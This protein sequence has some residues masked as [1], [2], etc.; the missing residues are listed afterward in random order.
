[1]FLGRRCMVLGLVV[2]AARVV[3]LGLMVVMRRRM[4]VARC[5]VMM[6]LRRVFCHLSLLPLLRNWVGP[7][8]A[9][10]TTPADREVDSI[11]RLALFGNGS[12]NCAAKTPVGRQPS[13]SRATPRQGPHICLWRECCA[14]I[15]LRID[16]ERCGTLGWPEASGANEMDAIAAVAAKKLGRFLAKDFREIFGSTQSDEAER[17]GALARTT[18]E[19]IS[20]SDALYHTYEHTMLVT[21][22]GRDILHGRTLAHG[23]EPGDY[24]HLIVACLLHDIGFV[25]GVLSGD[26]KTEFVVDKNGRTVTLPRGASDA[27]LAPYHV[28]RSKLFVYE[29][30]GKSASFDAARVAAAIELTRFPPNGNADSNQTTLEQRLVQAADLIGQLGDPLYPRKANAL[31][32]EF[33]EIGSNRQLGYASPADLVEKFP[34]FY[35]TTVSAHVEEGMKYLTLTAAGRQWIANLHNHIFNAE[36]FNWLMGPQI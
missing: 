36:H 15:I 29:R 9:R 27:S 20:R 14:C 26:T 10:P 18:L 16:H 32:Y 4:V 1:M 2:L 30:L 6:L 33:E 22:V 7:M 23:L 5:G 12:R 28:D 8:V 24:L 19:C 3:M 13:R 21:M 34:G 35:W 31:F 25:R 17:L 11:A